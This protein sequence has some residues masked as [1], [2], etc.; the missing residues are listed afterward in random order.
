MLNEDMEFEEESEYMEFSKA[1]LMR[2]SKIKPLITIPMPGVDD[3]GELIIRKTKVPCKVIT[4]RES[5]IMIKTN[6]KKMTKTTWETMN[7][8]LDW[9]LTYEEFREL[10][11][12][13]VNAIVGEIL[14]VSGYAEKDNAKTVAESF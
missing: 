13:I 12:G 5:E 8:A 9:D 14:K 1:E 7:K 3:N 4:N 10:G 6:K 11:F 2:S